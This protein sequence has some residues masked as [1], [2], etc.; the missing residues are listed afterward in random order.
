MP[1]GAAIGA[2]GFVSTHGTPPE[3]QHAEILD[4]AV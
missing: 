4:S 1:F 3:A 2:S